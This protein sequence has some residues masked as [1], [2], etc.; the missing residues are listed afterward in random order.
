MDALYDDEEREQQQE[1]EELHLGIK[2]QIQAREEARRAGWP[3]M[4]TQIPQELY[5]KALKHQDQLTDTERQLLLRRGDL[6]GKAL[7]QPSSLTGAERNKLIYRPPPDVISASI[8]RASNGSLS[9]IDQLVTKALADI[10]SLNEAE[11][12]LLA[13]DFNDN[14]SRSPNPWDGSP[15]TSEALKLVGIPVDQRQAVTA[16]GIYNSTRVKQ[17]VARSQEQRLRDEAQRGAERDRAIREHNAIMEKINE[18]HRHR[19]NMPEDEWKRRIKHYTDERRKCL[20]GKG[21]ISE[22]PTNQRPSKVPL[23]PFSIYF[24]EQ[25][26]RLDPSIRDEQTFLRRG[27]DAL[28]EQ[29]RAR[30]EAE[31]AAY[32]ASYAINPTEF[33]PPLIARPPSPFSYYNA[34]HRHN[35]WNDGF[36]E[37]RSEC[38]NDPE[39]FMRR[40]FE[41]LPKKERDRYEA[42]A[43]AYAAELSSSVVG[44]PTSPEDPPGPPHNWPYDNSPVPYP[45]G[46]LPT[47]FTCYVDENKATV[48]KENLDPSMGAP[49]RV[50]RRRFD[51]LTKEEHAVYKEKAASSSADPAPR[52]PN[53]P[54]VYGYIPAR[55]GPESPFYF[56]VEECKDDVWNENLDPFVEAPALVMRFRY[57][58]L[59]AEGQARYVEKAARGGWT[60]SKPWL[61]NLLQKRP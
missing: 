32:N 39:T 33:Y 7:A 43:A 22:G 16:A 29:K 60:E 28:P 26:P 11:L 21:W 42:T 5:E 8:L 2:R 53:W 20:P 6:V 48:W 52:P 34:E 12:R 37:A 49:V 55:P 36:K 27:W 17:G 18:L 3:A 4:A 19:G 10:K 46:Y 44:V 57:E 9:T 59:G 56:Y 51:A 25:L 38:D 45:R 40:R 47:P 54:Y 14:Q 50:M 35:I 58:A 13:S 41:A 1:M 31:A 24:H 23:A 15:G 61:P 30:Y